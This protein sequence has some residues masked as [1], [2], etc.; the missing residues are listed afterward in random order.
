MTS[1]LGVAAFD[2]FF[3]PPHLT[4]A[5]SNT[6][7]LLTFF[8]LLAVGIVISQLT[9]TVRG[10]AVAVQ[11]REAETVELYE[12]GRDLTV[13]ADLEAVSRA[14]I[15]HVSQ[16]LGCQVAIFLPDG[17][18]AK[19]YVPPAP[20]LAISDND[21]AVADWTF[22][23]GQVAGHAT[24]TLPEFA[25]RHQPLKT[26]RGVVGVLGISRSIRPGI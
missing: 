25:M 15:S 4:L 17:N 5:V 7:Y 18:R 19:G 23:H 21:L 22:E 16:T 11:R 6:E 3:V 1:I 10:Q 14:A 9:A 13:A 12:L 20:D 24:D 2:Y 26:T 8:G